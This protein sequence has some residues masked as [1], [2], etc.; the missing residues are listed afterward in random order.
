LTQSADD[1]WD[2]ATDLAL[3]RGCEPDAMCW[4]TCIDDAYDTIQERRDMRS[5]Y[6]FNQ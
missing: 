6:R 1:L 5:E 4:D 2:E 3:Q